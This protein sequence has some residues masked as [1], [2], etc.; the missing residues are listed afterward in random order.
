M[1]QRDHFMYLYLKTW[2]VWFLLFP[3]PIPFKFLNFVN[4][5]PAQFQNLIPSWLWSF[6]HTSCISDFRCKT[7]YTKK[8]SDTRTGILSRRSIQELF[9]KG[10]KV[11]FALKKYMSNFVNVPA[12]LSCKLFDTLIRPILLYNILFEIRLNF[13]FLIFTVSCHLKHQVI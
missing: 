11:L 2:L 7:K 5:G 6:W 8:L 12:D 13:V 10:L 9:I 3:S 4:S 1:H